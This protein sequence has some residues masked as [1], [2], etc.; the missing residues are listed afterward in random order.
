LVRN[1]CCGGFSVDDWIL[2]FLNALETREA[3]H[4]ERQKNNKSC[5]HS[6]N[7]LDWS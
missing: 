6:C 5:H 1:I 4:L 3:K 7:E 2:S